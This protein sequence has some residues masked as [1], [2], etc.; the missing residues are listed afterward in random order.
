MKKT[1]LV[2]LASILTLLFVIS[3]GIS[4]E[5]YDEVSSDLEAAQAEIQSLQGDLSAKE[6]EL[7]AAQT[8]I[9]S[10]Q[11]DLSVKE[12]QV[13]AAQAQIQL[14]QAEKWAL[15]SELTTSKGLIRYLY[16]KLGYEEKEPYTG[17]CSKRPKGTICLGFPD[18]YVWL[19]SDSVQ[20]WEELEEGDYKIAVAIGFK[21]RYYHVL[22]TMWIKEERPHQ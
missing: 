3:C 14:L 6:S 13:D 16:A 19:V 1:I 22:D 17:N 9:Q 4:Q 10:L 8:D 18:G 11:S 12:K 2:V 20:G 7:E 5:A 15:S 21:A